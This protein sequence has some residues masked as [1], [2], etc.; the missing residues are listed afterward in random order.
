MSDAW[1]VA[2][3]DGDTWGP[4]A[5][6]D[7]LRAAVAKQFAAGA[8]VWQVDLGE[9]QPL[10]RHFGNAMNATPSTA[11][12]RE[13]TKPVAGT[14]PGGTSV[15]KPPRP[16]TPP[17]LRGKPPLPKNQA[18]IEAMLREAQAKKGAI[19]ADARQNA[20]ESAR[21]LAWV[22]KRFA[23][24]YIDVGSLGLFGAS[25][26]W[27]A[28]EGRKGVEAAIAADPW[29][30]LFMALALWF[31]AESLL[32]GLFGTT[33]G[34]WLLGL[35]VRDARGEAPGIPRA[36]KRSFWVYARGLGFGLLFVTPFAIL[37]A[38]A[39][40]LNKGEAPWDSGLVV[41][42]QGASVQWQAIAFLLVFLWIAA[43]EGWWLD[44]ASLLMR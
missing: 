7:L 23:A 13:V 41:D 14:K 44:L 5:F 27:A 20:T 17:P 37:I 31:V 39:Q 1:Y 11:A 10:S 6:Q 25:A 8:L 30:L 22:G 35:R 9:W 18:Q 26:W 24:R 33:P 2:E 34:K 4:Y 40:T 29:L 38:G 43:S 3:P 12:P 32:I 16:G 36:F 28:T 15:P 19:A 21:K 42:E